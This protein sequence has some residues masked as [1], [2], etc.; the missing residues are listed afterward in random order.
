VIRLSRHVTWWVALALTITLVATVIP[1]VSLGQEPG[2][3][4][5]YTVPPKPQSPA[6]SIRPIPRPPGPP[7]WARGPSARHAPSGSASTT[8]TGSSTGYQTTG[9]MTAAVLAVDFDDNEAITYLS[10]YDDMLFDPEGYPDDI[11]K[12][13]RSYYH[14]V[15]YYDGTAGLDVAGEVYGKAKSHPTGWADWIRAPKNYRYYTSGNYGFGRYPRNAQK[16]TEDS[17]AAADPY[18]DFSTFTTYEGSEGGASGT[19]VSALFIVHAGPGA[20]VTGDRNDIWS[21]AWVTRKPILTDDGVYVYR[22]IMMA[23]FSPMGTFGHEFGH[24]LGLPDLYDY[25][26]SSAGIGAWGMMAYGTWNDGGNTPAHMS[27]WCKVEAAWVQAQDVTQSTDTS[28]PQVEESPTIY[29]LPTGKGGEYF[30]VE[31]RQQVYFDAALPGGGLLIWH[32]DDNVDN[33]DDETHYHV[34]VEQADGNFDLENWGNAGDEGDPFPG[35]TDNRT[36]GDASTPNSNTYDGSASGVA[37]TD[38]SDSGSTM[39]ATMTG[40]SEEIH[41]VAVTA[42]STPSTVEK[43][44]SVSIDV[45]VENQGTY[46]ETLDVTLTDD[47]DTVNIGIQSVTLAS[48]AS[49]T[50]K[51]SWDT[52]DAT[53]GDHIL[54]ADALL[55]TD[56]DPADNTKSIVVSVKERTHD[57]AVT[58]IDAPS[59]VAKDTTVSI[60][61]TV[62]NQGTYDET[63]DVTLTDTPPSGGTAGTISPTSWSVT[64][65]AGD[66]TTVT[67]DWDTT[68]ASTGDHTLTGT[69]GPVADETATADNT[70][71][72]V[73]TVEERVTFRRQIAAGEDDVNSG[74]AFTSD[75]NEVY[76]GVDENCDPSQ[77]YSAGFRFTNVQIPQDALIVSAHLE[78]IVDGPYNCD[79]SVELRGEDTGS[80]EAF[81]SDHQPST[82]TKTGNFV[83]WDITGAWSWGK[84]LSSPDIRSVIQEIINRS[85]WSP[86][87]ALIVTGDTI[88]G[89]V[90]KKR[91]SHRRVFAY[92]RDPQSAA[93]LVVE[94]GQ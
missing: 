24:T 56:S 71:Y 54:R 35:F 26:G 50:V 9:S 41:D 40:Y 16:L 48:G 10:H 69:A 62:K 75:A 39:T 64:L 2:N 74:C 52:S 13:L 76:F 44:D 6:M 8:A 61:V 86:G 89:T 91:T 58:A 1:G 33:N 27:A 53:L 7:S 34:A 19:F 32:I 66:L 92:E 42:I 73:V 90:E 11:T 70:K 60:D 47:T 78:F 85:D 72:I 22:Y 30:L 87:N 65:A 45:T 36:F 38:I 88:E 84:P 31:N 77:L 94:Y 67:F 49:A 3:T 23:E 20:E 59:P 80:A 55:E 12:S 15:S 68:E 28:L 93:V 18:V 43:G 29:R 51:F 17:V 46:D 57:V 79:M 4:L 83:R 5:A 21:H 14:E 25:D 37:V 63:F 82:L 81:S